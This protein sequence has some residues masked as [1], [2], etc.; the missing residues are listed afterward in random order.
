MYTYLQILLKYFITYIEFI[1]MVTLL[2]IDVATVLGK[3]DVVGISIFQQ[4]PEEL[5]L[6]VHNNLFVL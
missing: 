2:N 3:Y 5:P 4:S 6:W 1:N